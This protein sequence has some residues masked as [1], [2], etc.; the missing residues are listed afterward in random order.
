[1]TSQLQHTSTKR[2]R[3]DYNVSSLIQA[4]HSLALRAGIAGAAND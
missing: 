3:V 4:F 1:M 2:K